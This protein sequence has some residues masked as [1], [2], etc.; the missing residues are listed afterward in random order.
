M[1]GFVVTVIA[2]KHPAGTVEVIHL[3]THEE[4]TYTCSAREAVIAAYA[5]EI[6]DLN[7][8]DYEARYG[9]FVQETKYGWSLMNWWVRDRNKTPGKGKGILVQRDVASGTCVPQEDRT[10]M[11]PNTHYVALT[12]YDVDEDGYIKNERG[13]PVAD[14]VKDLNTAMGRLEW[15]PEEPFG[16]KYE[17]FGHSWDSPG[18][19]P[20]WPN[21]WSWIAC[22]A[23]TGGSEGHYV[24]IEVIHRGGTR[25]IMAT[26]KTFG[27]RARAQ[28]IAS[29][30]ALLLGA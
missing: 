28:L 29:R 13:R 8:A 4:R 2:P 24:H 30:A 18:K 3:L 17:G 27:G 16:G 1:K 7:T 15:P 21:E 20:I 25:Q 11:A 5:Q 12:Y 9:R 22:F 10:A 26:H 6:G 14:I 19:R 23:V